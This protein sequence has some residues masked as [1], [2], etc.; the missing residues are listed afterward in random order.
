MASQNLLR[1]VIR[2]KPRSLIYRYQ[3]QVNAQRR[4][5]ASTVLLS[6]SYEDRTVVELRDEA[7]K[8]GLPVYVLILY[9][10]S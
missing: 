10:R 6:K 9:Y 3:N 5:L 1:S 7:R 2:G 8:R 4:T